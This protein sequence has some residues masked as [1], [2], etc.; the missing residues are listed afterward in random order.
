[1]DT[2]AQ[3]KADNA[4][5]EASLK[6][7]TLICDDLERRLAALQ[8][9]FLEATD[10][11]ARVEA[12]AL[13]CETRLSLAERLVSG[14]ASENVRW[15]N[16]V[17]DLKA[18][19]I[20][21]IGDVLLSASFVS[22]IGAFDA[23]LRDSLWRQSWLEDLVSRE[24][25]ITEG[26]DPLSVLA[27]DAEVATWS[28]QGLP[29]DRI[30]RENAAI[31]TNCMRWPLMID[32]QLQ[33]I[34]WVNA[35]EGACCGD[36]EETGKKMLT[37]QLT[38][39]NWLRDLK[40][41]IQNGWV[42]IVENLG[43]E[44]D[45][46][47]EPVLMRQVVRRGHNEFVRLAG[48]D[49]SYDKG[50]RLYLQT[51]LSNPHYRP[52]IAAQCT[53]L[54]FLVTETG[55]EDQLLAKV[56]FQEEPELEAHAA[57]LRADFNQYKIQLRELENQLLE[58]LANAPDDI[59]SDVALIEGLET[60][61]KTATEIEEAV[62]K[63]REMQLSTTKARNQ[64]MPVASEAAMLYFMI[65]QVSKR[66]FR[67]GIR[68]PFLTHFFGT[69]LLLRCLHHFSQSTVVWSQSHVPVLA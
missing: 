51:K 54:N 44:V 59:L 7:V 46:V 26:I 47:L 35:M 4:A 10:E 68:S 66:F 57:K 11:K 60:T 17:E 22:Y 33:G 53:I 42:L 6:E 34:K 1:M 3:C 39:K 52:E 67:N 49:I 20:S 41:A 15:G 38:H 21:L 18:K 64:Y 8:E 37:V 62:K 25:P 5:A 14:L 24:I 65:I 31:V 13:N 2:L 55:L 69:F 30:S 43:E 61:K 58:R 45:S 32:P 19:K 9:S 29:A 27:N 48:E 63:G 50:F 28:N 36:F 40:Q 12:E 16:E 23:P 56:V